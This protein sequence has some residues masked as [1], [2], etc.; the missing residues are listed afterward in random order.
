MINLT[1]EE[2]LILEGFQR[3]FEDV[4]NKKKFLL[5]GVGGYTK[6]LL[7]NLNGYE[8]LGLM[9]SEL[10]GK[11]IYDMPVFSM[12]EAK[13]MAD[14]VVIVARESAVSIIYS[15]IR[16]LEGEGITIFDVFGRKPTEITH[17]YESISD[18]IQKIHIGDILELIQSHD[19]IA[20]DI[21]DTLLMRRCYAPSDVFSLVSKELL[22]IGIEVEDFKN[23]RMMA[24]KEASADKEPCLDD[25]YDL[26]SMKY[27]WDKEIQQRVKAI[28]VDIE[29]DMI[30][31]RKQVVDIYNQARRGKSVY[32]I[33]DMYFSKETLNDILCRNEITG[34]Q[35]LYVS[36]HYNKT[37]RKGDLFNLFKNTVEGKILHIG[38]NF[39]DDFQM[40]KKIGLDSYWLP[41]AKTIVEKSDLINL[42]TCGNSVED[43][44]ILGEFNSSILNNPFIINRSQ[45]VLDNPKSIGYAFLGP[46]V[47][48]YLKWMLYSLK[49]VSH[50]KIIFFGRDGL[51][52]YN[53]YQLYCNHNKD[54][55][56]SIYIQA[57]RRALSVAGIMNENDID[58]IL[59][60]PFYGT[61]LELLYHRFGLYNINLE[62]DDN[63]SITKETKAEHIRQIVLKYKETILQNAQL[64][65]KN[66]L[67]YLEKAGLEQKDNLIV[68]DFVA[69]GTIQHNFEKI[70]ERTCR[71]VYVATC[72]IPNNYFKEGDIEA[73]FGNFCHYDIHYSLQKWYIY[74][75]M[76]FTDYHGMM[77][78]CDDDGRP[79][80]DKSCINYSQ[81]IKCHEGIYEYVRRSINNNRYFNQQ[82]PNI[83]L[84]DNLI[85]LLFSDLVFWGEKTR[86]LLNYAN[87]YDN[88]HEKN[89]FLELSNRKVL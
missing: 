39:N 41:S 47:D 24:E 20:F 68:F 6:M 74:L 9:D 84:I 1:Y 2:S 40:A 26:L 63:I 69:A 78:K 53:A 66:Y 10:I 34:Y 60:R 83:K 76:I 8:I 29:K 86:D 75:E 43:R 23:S 13:K 44:L 27:K 62:V 38:D 28:E 22:E 30:V 72:N 12:E 14:I 50:G 73:M 42:L 70:T 56:K 7:D 88:E 25:I 59:K 55:P 21:F 49:Q 5:Y 71:G 80:F 79:I 35:A 45:I 15:R 17:Q 32:L 65:R 77:I 16:E 57:S 54:L 31:P 81:L 19:V 3:A 85:D 11:T 87:E 4:R 46:F 37:K 58:T 61:M 33:S 18:E 67:L 89:Y 36:N 48:S 82:M 64:E 51:V 52:F